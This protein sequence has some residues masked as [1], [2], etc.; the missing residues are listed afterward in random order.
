[1][2]WIKVI[3]H[4]IHLIYND[5]FLSFLLWVIIHLYLH[6]L[7]LLTLSF[8]TSLCILDVHLDIPAWIIIA[9]L[10]GSCIFSFLFNTTWNV[11]CIH[12]AGCGVGAVLHEFGL[13]I[14]RFS[15]ITGLAII[16]IL[17]ASNIRIVATILIKSSGWW[18][19]FSIVLIQLLL[20]RLPMRGYFLVIWLIWLRNFIILFIHTVFVHLFDICAIC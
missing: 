15:F 5:W 13:T 6:Y 8:V 3:H 20:Y 9:F 17:S 1:M 12:F 2:S 14:L 10:R 11:S 18:L 16:E 19:Y 4:F 7:K